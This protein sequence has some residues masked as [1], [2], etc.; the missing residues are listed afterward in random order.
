MFLAVTFVF[1]HGIF[2]RWWLDVS[3][4]AIWTIRRR[5][6]SVLCVRNS[7]RP[8]ISSQKRDCVQVNVDCKRIKNTAWNCFYFFHLYFFLFFLFLLYIFSV[9]VVRTGIWSWTTYYWIST[10][11]WELPILGCAN[12]KYIWIK[13]RTHFAV[14][15]ITW[16]PR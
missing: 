15:P 7:V 2:E 3:H 10:G 5:P 14:R 9:N 6:F 13:Q 11:T 4:P 16:R 1:C 8:Q 12:F